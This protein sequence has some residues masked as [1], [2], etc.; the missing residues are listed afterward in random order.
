MKYKLL[1]N[2]KQKTFAIILQSGDSVKA[3]LT[4]FIKEQQIHAAQF[5]AIGA[6]S[7][8]T[9]GFFDFSIKDYKRKTFKQQA[10]VLTMNGDISM[11]NNEPVIHAHVVLGKEDGSAYG[12]HLFDAL[13]HPTLEIIL[14]ESPAWLVRKMDEESRIPLIAVD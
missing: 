13:V 6:F 10:E 2:D 8:T 11:Y 9:I 14:T 1:N 5:T 7:E 4:G 12:G 3:C